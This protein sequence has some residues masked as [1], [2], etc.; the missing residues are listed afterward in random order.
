MNVRAALHRPNASRLAWRVLA[1]A[2]WS[3][4]IP[5][6]T[7]CGTSPEELIAR[8]WVEESWAYEKLDRPPDAL[9]RFE[10]IRIG[11]FEGRAVYRHEA[12]YWRL[13]PDRRF[14]IS[15]SSG[16]VLRGRW[17]LKGRGHILTLRHERGGVE[18]FDVKDLSADR[19]VLNFDLGMEVR[20]IGSL[21]FRQG[22][23]KADIE[24]AREAGEIS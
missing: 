20:G 14:E 8:K 3:S 19:L 16:E 21:T 1:M 22:E 4:M 10:G 13:Y 7:A 2:V 12:E 11:A 17:R 15:L 5:L 24:P 9:R 6:L 18:E 23:P